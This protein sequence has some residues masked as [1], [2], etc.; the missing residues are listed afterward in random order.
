MSLSSDAVST[1]SYFSARVFFCF[2][3]AK[4]CALFYI[5]HIY[6]SEPEKPSVLNY[7]ESSSPRVAEVCGRGRGRRHVEQFCMRRE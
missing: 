6:F 4:V 5:L 2:P 3:E 1:D 7:F